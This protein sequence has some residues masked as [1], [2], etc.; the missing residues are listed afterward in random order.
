[1]AVK[2]LLRLWSKQPELPKLTMKHY[3]CVLTKRDWRRTAMT[4]ELAITPG[5]KAIQLCSANILEKYLGKYKWGRDNRYQSNHK[6]R[7]INSKVFIMRPPRVSPRRCRLRICKVV[8]IPW[9]ILIKTW[10]FRI[11]IRIHNNNWQWDRILKTSKYRS[12][13]K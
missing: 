5:S 4:L 11:Q 10:S 3:K 9:A 7:L 12:I 1:M 2:S 6:C 8:V 13:K